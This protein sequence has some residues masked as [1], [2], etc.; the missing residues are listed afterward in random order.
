[1]HREHDGEAQRRDRR[2]EH[3][4][5]HGADDEGAQV[6]QVRRRLEL[7][8]RSG[9]LAEDVAK[10]VAEFIV[11]RAAVQELGAADAGRSA[12][13][14]STRHCRSRST[15]RRTIVARR[16]A[17]SSALSREADCSDRAG[18]A[19]ATAAA[20]T[21]ADCGLGAWRPAVPRSDALQGSKE[22]PARRCGFPE[23]DGRETR[24]SLQ[25]QIQRIRFGA[26]ACSRMRTRPAR[27]R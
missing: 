1:M 12:A 16:C 19:V 10:F 14:A 6:L 21:V 7:P 17:A 18:E 5:K 22:R 11:A 4:E 2:V 26:T 9:L 24:V 8:R 13:T 27:Y 3:G 20:G 25:F 15:R 23:P